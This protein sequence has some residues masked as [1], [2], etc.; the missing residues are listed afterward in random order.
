MVV[1]PKY[2]TSVSNA[3][4]LELTGAIDWASK[5]RLPV[6]MESMAQAVV[7]P[8][9]DSAGA[10]RSVAV[11]NSTISEQP[12]TTL[13]LRGCGNAKRFM[14]HSVGERAQKLSYKRDGDDVVLTIPEQQGWFMGWLSV[15]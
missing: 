13:R 6:I 2:S 5:G 9:V 10:L 4:R 11:L 3:E 12:A 1:I 8:R 14:W 15:E 7:V